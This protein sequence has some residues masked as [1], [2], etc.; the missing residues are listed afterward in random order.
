[1]LAEIGPGSK[2]QHAGGD[3]PDL[4]ERKFGYLVTLRDFAS[5]P[6]SKAVDLKL[7]VTTCDNVRE[8]VDAIKAAR[9]KATRSSRKGQAN[10][11]AHLAFSVPDRGEGDH[12]QSCSPSLARCVAK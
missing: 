4:D 8:A 5:I 6:P 2:R 3:Q 11:T 9:V 12:R 7:A 10:I 1:V